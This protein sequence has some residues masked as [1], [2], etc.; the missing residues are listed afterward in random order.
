LDEH[1]VRFF[2]NPTLSPAQQRDFAAPFGALHIHPVYPSDKTVP[3]IMI[4]E[5]DEKLKAHQNNWHTD[6]TFIETPPFGSVLYAD[7][8]PTSGGDTIWA[9]SYAAFEVLSPTLQNF[10]LGCRRC[11][12]SRKVSRRTGF[13]PM[14]WAKNST[15]PMP[16]TSPCCIRWCGPTRKPGGAGC[17]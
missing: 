6:V 11:M 3:E 14:A 5:Y 9:S 4:L 15:R 17:S 7:D 12:I 8:V 16:S 1:L 13:G 2:H 10:Y